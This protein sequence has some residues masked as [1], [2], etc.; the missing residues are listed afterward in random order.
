MPVFLSTDTDTNLESV[1]QTGTQDAICGY[2]QLEVP[3]GSVAAPGLVFCGDNDSGIAND[4]DGSVTLVANGTG[5]LTATPTSITGNSKFTVPQI[6]QT[7]GAV[8]GHVLQSDADGNGSW[9]AP[10]ATIYAAN[11]TLTGTRTV[12]IDTNTLNLNAAAGSNS[13]NLSVNQYGQQLSMNNGTNLTIIDNTGFNAYMQMNANTTSSVTVSA[14]GS[15][16]GQLR[17]IDGSG[18]TP[19]VK[20][21]LEY[22]SDGSVK[23][24]PPVFVSDG[25]DNIDRAGASNSFTGNSCVNLTGANDFHGDNSLAIGDANDVYG[26][27]SLVVGDGNTAAGNNIA[28]VGRNNIMS[29][30]SNESSIFG[31]NNTFTTTGGNNLVQ[32]LNHALSGTAGQCFIAGSN[33][34]TDTART[35]IIGR[36]IDSNSRDAKWGN[37]HITLIGQNGD[38]L[39]TGNTASVETNTCPVALV[40]FNGQTSA[41]PHIGYSIQSTAWLTPMES[42]GGAHNSSGADFAEYHEV[43]EP[44][45]GGMGLFVSYAGAGKVKLAEP[46]EIIIGIISGNASVIGNSTTI[47][48]PYERD[49]EMQIVKKKDF[50]GVTVNRVEERISKLKAEE[51]WDVKPLEDYVA[52]LKAGT[53]I[54]EESTRA[55]I[56]E[57]MRGM[58]KK[59]REKRKLA[60]KEKEKDDGDGDEEDE[61]EEVEE[62]EL[63]PT[64]TAVM[65]PNVKRESKKAYP[66]RFKVVGLVGLMFSK[67]DGSVEDGK[68]VTAG[69]GGLATKSLVPTK[70]MCFGLIDEGRCWIQTV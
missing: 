41:N 22:Q 29:F 59:R 69:A 3:S 2:D 16:D 50:R 67:H 8:D 32:G 35:V 31:E 9:T 61:V 34:K 20:D 42:Y 19:T 49:A 55:V 28:I 40:M 60:R 52:E 56:R 12:S 5:V 7:N 37:N 25:S 38:L 53:E 47:E 66:N 24:K 54:I 65:K 70:W 63:T 68:Y 62:E 44:F 18:A 21:V 6:Q 27:T 33:N 4:A 58:R 45:E 13:S 30:A 48:D 51:D 57:K 43:A 15:G 14:N 23:F 64:D 46:G 36:N 11:S 26:D 1:I 10:A 17:I 39:N